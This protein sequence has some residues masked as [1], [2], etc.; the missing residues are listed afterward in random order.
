MSANIAGVAIAAFGVALVAH[1][2]VV[3]LFAYLLTAIT[4]AGVGYFLL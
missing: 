4:V 1:D 3:A 2:G